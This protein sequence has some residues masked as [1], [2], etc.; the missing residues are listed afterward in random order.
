INLPVEHDPHEPTHIERTTLKRF[1]SPFIEE[2]LYLENFKNVFV[3]S[4]SAL[5]SW[6][7]ID[8]NNGLD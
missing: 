2:R 8:Q 3:V 6:S 1:S 4:F 7:N 5:L